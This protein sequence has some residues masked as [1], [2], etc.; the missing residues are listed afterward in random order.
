M[1]VYWV[2]LAISLGSLISVIIEETPGRAL[3]YQCPVK[4]LYISR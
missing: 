1:V 4:M 2:L 3:E